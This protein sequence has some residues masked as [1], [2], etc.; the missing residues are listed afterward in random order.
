M[1]LQELFKV[2]CMRLPRYKNI[3]FTPYQMGS[4]IYPDIFMKINDCYMATIIEMLVS[5]EKYNKIL[6]V[7]GIV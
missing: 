7:F 6:G 2:I 4:L 3:G 1:E 5:T